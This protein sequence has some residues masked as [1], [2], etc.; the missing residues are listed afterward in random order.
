MIGSHPSLSTKTARKSHDFEPLDGAFRTT[1][2]FSRVNEYANPA[3]KRRFIK[4]N[5]NGDSKPRKTSPAIAA[6]AFG[7]VSIALLKCRK[8]CFTATTKMRIKMSALC[9]LI[10]LGFAALAAVLLAAVGIDRGA[11]AV[12]RQ[13][14]KSIDDIERQLEMERATYD[15]AFVRHNQ[16]RTDRLNRLALLAG[17][18]NRT[19]K[20][21]E[22]DRES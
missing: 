16:A 3:Q 7:R 18:N 9:A 10:L 2:S 1:G 6:S 13:R 4:P 21:Q 19:P 14:C 17:V 5:R 15:A 22:P 8:G 12:D 20:S 11:K